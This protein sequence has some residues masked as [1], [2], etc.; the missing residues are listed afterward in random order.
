LTAPLSPDV[1]ENGGVPY[2]ELSP[3]FER[4]SKQDAAIEKQLRYKFGSKVSLQK[5][6]KGGQIVIDYYSEEDLTRLIDILLPD[7][8]F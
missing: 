6:E 4:L 2:A 3:L 7:V 5:G 1:R 8:E